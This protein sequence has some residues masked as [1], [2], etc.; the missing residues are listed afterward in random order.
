MGR[1]SVVG[2]TLCALWSE[3]RT[4]MGARFS[5]PVQTG[6]NALPATRTIGTGAIYRG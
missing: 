1:D 3:V 6:A 5:V 2:I 4:P